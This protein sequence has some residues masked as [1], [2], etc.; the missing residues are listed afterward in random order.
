MSPSRAQ[1]RADSAERCPISTPVASAPPVDPGGAVRAYLATQVDAIMGGDLALRAGDLGLVHPTRVACRRFRSTL[2]TFGSAFPEGT[3]SR[4]GE[5]LRWWAGV[6]GPVRDLEV[7]AVLLDELLDGLGDAGLADRLRPGLHDTLGARSAEAVVQV[8]AALASQ[9]HDALVASLAPFVAATYDDVDV[10]EALTETRRLVARRL[11]RVD[12][13]ADPA[14]LHD[15]RKAAKRARYAAEAAVPALAGDAQA[16]QDARAQVAGFET[17]QGVL[18]RFQDLAVAAA[19][20]DQTDAQGARMREADLAAFGAHVAAEA[21]EARRGA[22]A[23]LRPHD[24]P[25]PRD[26]HD[27][28]REGPVGAHA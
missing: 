6:L 21:D 4:L 19:V 24:L 13:S 26:P 18:G 25:D 14:R 5:E 28:H 1:V 3:T 11:A 2:R 16:L 20:L 9:R 27:P 17:L 10:A 12:E 8:R 7:L 15:V 22:L 23:A